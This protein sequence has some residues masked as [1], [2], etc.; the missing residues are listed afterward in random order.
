M[1]IGCRYAVC[2]GY[3][4]SK[5]DDAIDWAFLLPS[6]DFNPP[7][8]KFVMTSWHADESI[9][10]VAEFFVRNTAFDNYIPTNF[11]LVAV[12]R[13]PSIDLAQDAVRRLL[14]GEDLDLK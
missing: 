14:A 10:E 12:G 4:C 3:E 7:D 11:V 5:W 2:S 13:D 9:P 8:E 1:S 6:D